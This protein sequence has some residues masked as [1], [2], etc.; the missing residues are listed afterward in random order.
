MDETA[1]HKYI[2]NHFE[3]NNSNVLLG[4][5]DDAAAIKLDDNSVFLTSSDTL[6]E[7]THFLI[8]KI[9]PMQLGKKAVSVAISDIAAMGGV[10]KFVLST[11]G[12]DK[13]SDDNF[14]KE[15]MNG[16]KI[17][18]NEYSVDLVGG[19]LSGS[20]IIFVD[21]TAIGKINPENIVKREGAKPGDT[22]YVTGNLGDSSLGLSLLGSS[23]ESEERNK[24]VRRHLEP[25]PRLK[26]GALLAEKKS[27]N[28]MIDVSDGL[29][30]DLSRI[31]EDFGVGAEIMLEQIPLSKEFCT[32]YKEV[33]ED[34]YKL[35]ISGGEDYELLFTSDSKN[36]TI[37]EISH[38]TGVKITNIGIIT[39]CPHIK[40]IDET[41]TE[42]KY[43]AKGFKHF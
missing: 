3:A 33:C 40:F 1:A 38:E 21:I 19:N 35:A 41:G 18:C 30:L 14:F 42:K 10:P 36:K 5:G 16:I 37:E 25:C 15:I 6:V 23:I 13:N 20:E 39:D 24:L 31:T 32:F 34:K 7:N 22:I 4:I 9:S 28:S 27:V 29:Y 11:I 2:K 26:M 43:S 12:I 8:G 17:S